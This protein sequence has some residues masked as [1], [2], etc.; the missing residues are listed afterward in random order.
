[1]S[2]RILT[3]GELN[4]HQEQTQAVVAAAREEL[5]QLF[6]I[7]RPAGYVVLMSNEHGVLV[8]HRLEEASSRVAGWGNMKGGVWSEEAEGTN[9][10]GTCLL[11]R[12]PITIHRAEHFRFQHI[13]SSCSAAPIFG[14]DD[15][16][17]GVLDISSTDP[18]LS[19]NAHKL[20]GA[21]VTES[22]RS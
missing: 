5:D 15:E 3:A 13:G 16:L 21:L 4:D 20:A 19:E 12:R 18:D 14:G 10:T 6:R 8:D 1:A 22:A 11:E 7:S 9:G 17:V 2:P